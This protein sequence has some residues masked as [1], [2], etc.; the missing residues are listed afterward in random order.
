M[1]KGYLEHQK[2]VCA[3]FCHRNTTI[4]NLYAVKEIYRII[5]PRIDSIFADM[6]SIC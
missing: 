1:P 5:K 4:F 6:K 2:Y 3:N